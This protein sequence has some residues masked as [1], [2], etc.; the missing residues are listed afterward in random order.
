M[1][2]FFYILKFVS[3]KKFIEFLRK[4][5]EYIWDY[6]ENTF[7]VKDITKLVRENKRKK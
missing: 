2:Y 7:V 3:D 1:E 6:D 4:N 5:P